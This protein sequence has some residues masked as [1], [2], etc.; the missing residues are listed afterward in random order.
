[1]L[2]NGLWWGLSLLD[3]VGRGDSIRIDVVWLQGYEVQVWRFW[4]YTSWGGR[5]GGDGGVVRGGL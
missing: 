2:D 3:G 1:M 5:M 4:F